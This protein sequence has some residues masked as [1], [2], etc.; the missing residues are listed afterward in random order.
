M[1]TCPSRKKIFF[2]AEIAE[3]ALIDA[4]ARYDYAGGEGPINVYQCE[5]CGYFH[6]TS[7]GTINPRLAQSQRDG[8]LDLKKAGDQWERKIN[9]RRRNK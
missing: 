2:T 9:T 4:R 7:K 3:D 1:K 5:D 6:L 8:K